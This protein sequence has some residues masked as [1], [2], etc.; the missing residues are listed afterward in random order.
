MLPIKKQPK[1]QCFCKRNPDTWYIFDYFSYIR[2]RSTLSY[3]SLK[4][5]ETFSNFAKLLLYTRLNVGPRDSQN[6]ITQ[7]VPSTQRNRNERSLS[8]AHRER[9]MFFELKK[10]RIKLRVNQWQFWRRRGLVVERRTPEREVGG[11]ILTQVAV[12]NS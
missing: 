1:D 6:K 9:G 10:Y 8:Q 11:S 3:N 5:K 4:S 2:G 12:L 7:P